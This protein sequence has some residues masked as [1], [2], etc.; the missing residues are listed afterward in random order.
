M[1]PFMGGR[2]RFCLG[3]PSRFCSFRVRLRPGGRPGFR[4]GLLRHASLGVMGF[5]P[6]LRLRL[7]LGSF[8][9]ILFLL[10][11]SFGRVSHRSRLSSRSLP[12]RRLRPRLRLCLRL[13]SFPHIW[14]L[15][16]SSFGIT[17]I[18]RR[19]DA[20]LPRSR[21]AYVWRNAVYRNRRRRC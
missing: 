4:A 1:L 5:G 18:L 10:R 20:F 9:H 7:R 15:L 3:P 6:S 13:A 17:R 2:G 8:P 19:L 11:H 21:L 12:I 16:G 14:L